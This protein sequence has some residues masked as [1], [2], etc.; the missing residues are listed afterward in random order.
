[1]SRTRN[2][3]PAFF[4]NETLA[5]LAPTTRL[6]F[7]GL[8][9]IADRS[10]RLE[11]RPKRIKAEVLPY[12]CVN[13]DDHLQAL[14]KAGFIQRYVIGAQRFICIPTWD[15]HQNPHIKEQRSTIPE[16][17]Q[18]CA[19][20][21]SSAAS[22]ADSPLS[23]S[24]SLNPSP[25]RTAEG[26]QERRPDEPVKA[27]NEF[28]RV[29]E[30]C[31]QHIHNRHP[32]ARR[33]I[34]VK[35]VEKQLRSIARLKPADQIETIRTVEHNHESHCATWEWKKDGGQFAKGLENWLAPTKGRWAVEAPSEL[36]LIPQPRASVATFAERNEQIRRQKFAERTT[37][38]LS[39]AIIH[40]ERS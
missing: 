13:A 28:D 30:E 31:A 17:F 40:R 1:M 33:D 9:T 24:D 3:K 38:D 34:G 12:D 29:V 8:W 14:H 35:S 19:S 18:T 21:T 32:L 16:P 4:K 10:G 11:D 37:E 27:P 7:C 22:P 5:G 2:I 23:I 39:D 36:A 15:K 25:L 6:L 20:P 26:E